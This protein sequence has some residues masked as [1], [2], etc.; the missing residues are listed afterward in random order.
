MQVCTV[1]CCLLV[2]ISYTYVPI[3]SIYAEVPLAQTLLSQRQSTGLCVCVCVS[4]RSHGNQVEE[5]FGL[6]P[7]SFAEHHL[8]P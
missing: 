1:I 6:P 4:G 7:E 8:V 3:L 5:W 2:V